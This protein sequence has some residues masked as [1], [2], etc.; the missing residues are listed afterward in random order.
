MGDFRVKTPAVLSKI[1]IGI[2]E[3]PLE[4]DEIGGDFQTR[5]FTV[6]M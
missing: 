5:I 1:L 3:N 4:L 6:L 2:P